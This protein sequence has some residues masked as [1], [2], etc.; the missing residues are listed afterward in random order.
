MT[1]ILHVTQK[2]KI[3]INLE[4]KHSYLNNVIALCGNFVNQWVFVFCI[5]KYL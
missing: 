3:T 4:Y 1:N 2:V 5:Y